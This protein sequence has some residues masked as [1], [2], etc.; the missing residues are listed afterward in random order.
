MASCR[1]YHCFQ[2]LA[3]FF[4]TF[5]RFQVI[6]SSLLAIT[7]LIDILLGLQSETP[8]LDKA[9][10]EAKHASRA[11]AVTISSA[12]KMFSSHKYFLE[13]LKSQSPGVRS[14]TYSVLG[15]FIKHIPHAYNEGNMKILSSAILGAFQEKDPACH[16]SMWDVVLLFSKRFPDSWH[17]GNIQKTVFTRF[18]HFLKKGCHGS[19]QVSYPTL[20]LFLDTIPPKSINGEQF[21][22]SFFQNLWAGRNP[23]HSLSDDRLTFFNALKECFLWGI[24][25]ASRFAHL[26]FWFWIF[27]FQ[28]LF[29]A[30][31]IHVLI[32]N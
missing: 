17:L 10:T 12:E 4:I 18:W 25:N 20:V 13:F 19:Q 11:K 21:L 29:Y 2:F 26:P 27:L 28:L 31:Q 5:S 30:I 8:D 16:S 6:S 32:L 9:S 24:Y 23:F 22:L 1:N 14:A 3:R 7:T 15:C